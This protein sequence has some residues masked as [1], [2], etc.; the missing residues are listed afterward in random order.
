M[1]VNIKV[2]CQIAKVSR[3]GYYKFLRNENSRRKKEEKDREDIEII[4]MTCGKKNV[5]K[6]G[7]RRATMSLFDQNIVMNHKKV[8]RLMDKFDLQAKIRKKNPYKQFLKKTEN[9]K[10]FENLLGRNFKQTVPEKVAGTDITYIP[11]QNKFIY[12]SAVKDYADGEILS[13]SIS[14]RIDMLLVSRTLDKLE[15]RLKGKTQ[16]FM[17]H[18][19]QGGHYTSPQYYTRLIK[20]G[21]I[22]SMSRKGNCID[23][24][25]IESFF[26]HMKDEVDLSYCKTFEDAQKEFENYIN[27]YNNKRRQWNRKKM[28][29]VQYRDHLLSLIAV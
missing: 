26:G 7:Y 18:S 21:I 22:Q 20:N 17:L 16:S 29:P 9:H 2:L 3:S 4:R 14:A 13:W 5:G 28:T 25:S 23:N 11:F 8:A 15:E 27:E 12:F 10:T 1:G 6:Y 24:A 19:D